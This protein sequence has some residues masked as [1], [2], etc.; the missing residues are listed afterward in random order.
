VWLFDT[1]VL[2]FRIVFSLILILMIVAFIKSPSG[3]DDDAIF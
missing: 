3:G 1:I 2:I